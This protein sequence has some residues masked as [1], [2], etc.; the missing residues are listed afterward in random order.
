[1][2]AGFMPEFRSGLSQSLLLA[3]LVAVAV[4]SMAVDGGRE[5][6]EGGEMSWFTGAILDVAA[7]VLRALESR[8]CWMIIR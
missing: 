5:T 6:G 8:C 4:L 7:P 3:A 2:D 1:M